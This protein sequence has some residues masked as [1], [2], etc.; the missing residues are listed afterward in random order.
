MMKNIWCVKIGDANTARWLVFM[1]NLR[2]LV[3]IV[4]FFRM[5][6]ACDD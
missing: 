6:L 2:C 5:S 1:H 4:C 3:G